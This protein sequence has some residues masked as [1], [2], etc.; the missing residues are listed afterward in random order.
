MGVV[1]GV[2]YLA[3]D[4]WRYRS[5]ATHAQQSLSGMTTERDTLDERAEVPEE[6]IKQLAPMEQ[7]F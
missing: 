7:T 1:L 4:F 5:R 6:Q 3:P 2:L